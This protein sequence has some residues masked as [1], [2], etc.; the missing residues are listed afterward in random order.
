MQLGAFSAALVEDLA[1]MMRFISA[2]DVIKTQII[3]EIYA[4]R[5]GL[6]A[7]SSSPEAAQQALYHRGVHDAY[8]SVVQSIEALT[9]EFSEDE[10]ADGAPPPLSDADDASD[11]S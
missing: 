10:A 5:P 9:L 7:A 3:N 2:V 11:E 6:E 1:S 8:V 4:L